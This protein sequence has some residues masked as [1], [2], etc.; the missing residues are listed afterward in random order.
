MTWKTLFQGLKSIIWKLGSGTASKLRGSNRIRI[1][2]TRRIRI[3]NTDS[4]RLDIWKT[5][6]KVTT[7]K[8]EQE[9]PTLEGKRYIARPIGWRR[10]GRRHGAKFLGGMLQRR[11]SGNAG[12]RLNYGGGSRR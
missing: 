6:P 7:Y 12:R 10:L 8:K 4:N 3:R 9:K 5:I 2:M 11:R 1:K